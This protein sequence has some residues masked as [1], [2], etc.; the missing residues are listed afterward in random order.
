M[1]TQTGTDLATVTINTATV[2]IDYIEDQNGSFVVTVTANDN[3]GCATTANSFNVN[4]SSVNEAPIT[5]TDSITVLEAGTATTTSAGSSN[6]LSNDNDPDGDNIIAQVVSSPNN[7][8]S[9]SLQNSGT[10]T[11]V[12]DGSE[13][14]T[15]SFTYRT[16]DGIDPGNTVTVTIQVIPV[17]DCPTVTNPIADITVQEDAADTVFSVS[18]VFDDV[19]RVGGIPDNLSYSVTHTGAGIATV[20]IN[21]AT[22]TIDYIE[23]QT[24]S[25]VVTLT[26]DDGAGCST[27]NDVF[28]VT[29]SP[30]N[31]PPVGLQD[32]IILNESGTA[33]TVTG[34]Y[35]CACKRFRS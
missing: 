2:T 31:D 4:I 24:G 28:N 17:N 27:V 10:F 12:H 3:A 13:T 29:V 20:T 22:I 16:F 6:V 32:Q 34:C 35:F 21:T 1:V 5:V 30:Q 14:T 15:D 8:S 9:F 11:Y 33:T 26:V 19:D 18:S 7:S 23:N 25:F